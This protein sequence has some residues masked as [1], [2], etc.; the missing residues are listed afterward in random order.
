MVASGRCDPPSAYLPSVT[1]RLLV[2]LLDT[3]IA[4]GHERLEFQAGG[5]YG[6]AAP[7]QAIDDSQ[8]AIDLQAKFACSFNGFERT[9]A[10]GDNVFDDDGLHAGFNRPFHLAAHPVLLGFFA[11]DESANVQVL[12]AR[13][14]DRRG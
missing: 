8:N 1:L 4:H 11:N 10:T 13:Q 14:G 12:L 5:F 7:F 6:F 9:P 2:S 3:Q